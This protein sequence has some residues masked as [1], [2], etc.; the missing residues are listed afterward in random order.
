M[1]ENLFT[2]NNWYEKDSYGKRISTKPINFYL[3]I[4][5]K[6]KVIILGKEYQK[7][8]IFKYL[9]GI[10][11]DSSA[12]IIINTTIFYIPT[13]AASLPW[14][15]VKENLEVLNKLNTTFTEIEIKNA[16]EQVGLSDYENYIPQYKNSGFRFRI[17]LARAIL[18]KSEVVLI[19]NVFSLLDPLTND[20]LLRLIN[21]ISSDNKTTFIIKN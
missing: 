10:K 5:D 4:E 12:E 15:T 2:V 6:G 18:L 17:L 9:A 8:D 20:E 1:P 19:E 16:I 11:K 21:K 3:P 14:L 13:E 7:S